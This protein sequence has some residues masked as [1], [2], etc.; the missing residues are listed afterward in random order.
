MNTELALFSVAKEALAEARRVDEVLDVRDQAQRMRLYGQQAGDR[1]VI[2]DANEI[3]SRAERRLGE[4][5]KAAHDAGQI[6]RGGRPSKSNVE[7]G[8]DEEPVFS[9]RLEDIG[10]SKKLSAS[11]QK[12]ASLDETAFEAAM[13]SARDKIISGAAAVVNPLKDANT[14]EKRAKRADREAELG[15]RQMALPVAKFGVILTDDEWDYETWSENGM[16]RSAANHYPTSSLEKLKERD[17]LSLAADDAAL[18]MW[19]TAPH[20]AQG[21]ELM[22]HRG[23]EYKTCCIWEKVYPG[24]GHGMGRWFWINHEILLVGTRGN[25]PAPA[26]GTQWPSVIEAPIGEHSAKPAIFH[27]LIEAY[28]PTLPKIE[29]N[30]RAARTGWVRWGYEAPPDEAA[31]PSTDFAATAEARA[32]YESAIAT[33]ADGKGHLTMATAEPILRAGRAA[34]VSPVILADDIGHPLGTIKTWLNRLGLTSMAHLQQ[35]NE[36]RASAA[37]ERREGK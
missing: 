33:L 10:V 36:Q 17:V 20:L 8:A 28:F 23:F 14:A 35:I 9:V 19:T 5:L 13:N 15:A 22:A 21:L 31:A 27:E 37:A 18:F 30:A 4:M 24:D 6:S 1:T 32:Y 7:T 12:L 29:L 2:A 26:P 16:D 3:I 34:G 25:V 11:S